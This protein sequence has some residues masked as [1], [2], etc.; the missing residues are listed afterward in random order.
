MKTLMSQSQFAHHMS[1]PHKRVS[2]PMIN[3]YIKQGRLPA[4]GSKL[5]MPDA[6]KAY[7]IIQAGMEMLRVIDDKPKPKPQLSDVIT[8]QEGQLIGETKFKDYT[9]KF[10]DNDQYNSVDI[11][12]TDFIAGIEST[13]DIKSAA[14]TFKTSV[15]YI[16]LNIVKDHEKDALI[17]DFQTRLDDELDS[18]FFVVSESELIEWLKNRK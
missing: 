3:R 8:L 7:H 15:D 12:S 5:I 1:T 2:Q 13:Q 18:T 6:E 11:H 17:Q 4:Q 10:Y 16:G 9:L 14:I